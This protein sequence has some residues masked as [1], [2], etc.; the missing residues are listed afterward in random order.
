MIPTSTLRKRD[1]PCNVRIGSNTV[2]ERSPVEVRSP[3]DCR[4]SA[5]F[6]PVPCADLLEIVEGSEADQRGGHE[7]NS[8]SF[9]LSRLA[10][11]F[12]N[13]THRPNCEHHQEGLRRSTRQGALEQRTEE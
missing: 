6:S 3:P 7:R 2:V 9:L 11:L 4:S 1:R 5:N 10:V 12:Y 8:L 13:Q